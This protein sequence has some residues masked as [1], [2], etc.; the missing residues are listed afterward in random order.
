MKA[1]KGQQVFLATQNRPNIPFATGD[2][3]KETKDKIFIRDYETGNVEWF[4]KAAFKIVRKKLKM[5][6]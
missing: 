2:F 1:K 6:I 5:V 4:G 3:I